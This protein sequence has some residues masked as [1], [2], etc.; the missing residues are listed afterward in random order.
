[1]V[2]RK[3]KEIM[4]N[5]IITQTTGRRYVPHQYEQYTVLEILQNIAG[6]VNE[7]LD[8]T[9]EQMQQLFVKMVQL[10]ADMLYLLNDGLA[11]EV[12]GQVQ[13]MYDNGEL[14]DVINKQVFDMIN[15]KIDSQN[16]NVKE[17]GAKGD[18]V[19]DDT[20][21][22]KKAIAIC[23]ESGAKVFFPSGTYIITETLEFTKAC[24]TGI[25]KGGFTLDS[26]GNASSIIKGVPSQIKGFVGLHNVGGDNDGITFS[27]SNLALIN[28]STCLKMSY[29][30]N[31]EFNNIFID[32]CIDGVEF[33]NSDKVGGLFNTWNNLY[34]N[35][36]DNIGFIL[37]G[38]QFANNN[39]FN[40]C[41][42]KGIVASFKG[43]VTGGYGGIN[44][45]FNQCE[46][47]SHEVIEGTNMGGR[48]YI[49]K[50]MSNSV[51]NQC[52]FETHSAYVYLD[53][54]SSAI[55]ND[56]VYGSF[57]KV[58]RFNDRACL[59]ANV[60]SGKI[61]INGGTVYMPDSKQEDV[62]FTWGASPSYIEFTRDMTKLV[63]SNGFQL[64]SVSNYNPREATSYQA[65]SKASPYLLL[66]NED[67]QGYKVTRSRGT[68]GTGY[69]VTHELNGVDVFTI[70][71][72]K[73]IKVHT[74][75]QIDNDVQVLGKDRGVILQ[76]D[77]GALFRIRVSDNG[78]LSTV[79]V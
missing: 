1:M 31:S 49:G 59:M 78:T 27:I 71:E 30:V 41:F 36:A 15:Y 5:R 38:N 44:N 42:F 22:I 40:N 26:S 50:R 52:Y 2:E 46:F 34:I 9:D 63:V 48:G 24:F 56:C 14:A 12:A 37:K 19:T 76:S 17:Q 21:A 25:S 54:T 29:V 8:L 13:E 60:N 55:M 10:D 58:N 4:E 11:L 74:K 77:G 16:Y 51:F 3:E 45:V 35:N 72:D 32:D 7:N 62:T 69:G 64:S 20:E 18:G 53:V 28:F 66:C 61:I 57:V 67:E 6:I 47:R 68:A 43:D 65:K 39:V 23:E 75:L 33:G 73:D 79:R 70:E